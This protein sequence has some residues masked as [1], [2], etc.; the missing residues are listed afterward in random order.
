MSVAKASQECP[1]KRFLARVGQWCGLCLKLLPAVHP[2]Q[3][4][5][6]IS[7]GHQTI[8][9]RVR[10]S[11]WNDGLEAGAGHP[12]GKPLEVRTA[13][14]G[15][16]S[17]F[18]WRDA[19]LLLRCLQ[20]SGP[21]FSLVHPHK[22]LFALDLLLNLEDCDAD[23]HQSC[24]WYQRRR[25]GSGRTCSCDRHSTVGGADPITLSTRGGGL[26]QN[27]KNPWNWQNSKAGDGRTS[28]K[29]R[30]GQRLSGRPWAGK[31]R[32]QQI[33]QAALALT[34]PPSPSGFVVNLSMWWA[35][36]SASDTSKPI[37]QLTWLAEFR[38]SM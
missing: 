38:I 13:L 32:R 9:R 11:L 16:Q 14:F 19:V 22:G 7:T 33:L 25:T 36:E 24:R 1:L 34:E 29:Y 23:S 20:A 8:P 10:R 2:Q 5:A 35:R 3:G 31:A 18:R 6:R 30:G 4:S 15:C 21:G 27:S 17:S 26:C 28:P 37:G 12:M